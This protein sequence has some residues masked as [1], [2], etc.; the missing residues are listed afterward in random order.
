MFLHEFP[1]FPICPTWIYGTVNLFALT[2]KDILVFFD[3]YVV[4]NVFKNS[5]DVSMIIGALRS[6]ERAEKKLDLFQI[7]YPFK[8]CVTEVIQPWTIYERIKSY[9][10]D[11]L[12]KIVL[13]MSGEYSHYTDMLY[14]LYEVDKYRNLI[15][16]M[17]K[18]T[19]F[20]GQNFR[21][22]EMDFRE[23]EEKF[24][25]KQIPDIPLKS[26]EHGRD[27]RRQCP[28]CLIGR[29]WTVYYKD[30]IEGGY[31][32]KCTQCYHLW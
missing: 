14:H 9:P 5:T 26:P 20:H 31:H 16:I 29:A 15:V 28:K 21:Y 17:M 13:K 1:K 30:S 7:M 12:L 19:G 10:K 2:R 22:A 6:K 23:P 25:L 4:D 3:H 24:R 8:E 32:H 27:E 18:G 11:Q